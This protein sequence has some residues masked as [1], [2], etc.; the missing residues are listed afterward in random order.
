MVPQSEVDS[1]V[2]AAEN[3]GYRKGIEQATE[4]SKN[5][6][7]TV[8]VT[9]DNSGNPTVSAPPKASATEAF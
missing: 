1:K 3:A 4:I 8:V 7:K 5:A 6:S 9:D 2:K